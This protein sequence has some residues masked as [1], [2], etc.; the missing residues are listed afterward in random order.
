[1]YRLENSTKINLGEISCKVWTRLN[2]LQIWFHGGS[3]YTFFCVC[4]L[5]W[6]FA[7]AFCAAVDAFKP[8]VISETILRRLL[9]QDV[10]YHIKAKN[11]D[12]ARSD[13][14]TVIYL[15][16]QW[17]CIAYILL[18]GDSSYYIKITVKPNTGSS[19]T[20]IY[21]KIWR[22]AT[23]TWVSFWFCIFLLSLKVLWSLWW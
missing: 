13:P 3:W 5:I 18:W 12:K 23:C 8:D 14:Q 20:T 11:R 22:S 2:C 7:C 15:Q 19:N 6:H 9:K 10:I 4:Y 21:L 1:M 17:N 16:V